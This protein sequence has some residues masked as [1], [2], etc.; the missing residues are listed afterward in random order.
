LLTTAAATTAAITAGSRSRAEDYIFDHL[1]DAAFLDSTMGLPT[2]GTPESVSGLTAEGIA[3]FVA[4]Q[5]TPARTV[6]SAAGA[7][8]HTAVADAVSSLLGISSSSAGS[9]SSGKR[10]E[11]ELPVA[12]F[13]GSDKRMR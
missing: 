4:Q 9:S 5:Y 2:L 13:V 7:V 10:E 6:V 1:H 8:E 11:V 12:T 3:A